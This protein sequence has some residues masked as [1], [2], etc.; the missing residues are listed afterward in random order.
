MYLIVE[1]SS[2]VQK[3]LRHTLKQQSVESAV[4]ASSM[5]EGRT[6]IE[7]QGAKIVSA[8]VDISLPDAPSGEMVEYV[9]DRN[10]PV[11]VLTGSSDGEQ[12]QALIKRGIAD[13]VVKEN[14]FSYQYAVRM[15]QRLN[16]NRAITALVVDDSAMMR[17]V[18]AGYLKLQC[19]RVIEAENGQEALEHLHSDDSI[20]LV[21]TDFN[22]PV[23]DGF[24]LVQEI[25]HR[26]DKRAISIIGLSSH[27]DADVSVQF[28][29]KGA[30]DFLQKPFKQEEFC[31][32]VT[33]NVEALEQLCALREQ[34]E[35]D[36]LTGLFNRRYFI[37]EG[38]QSISQLFSDDQ[39][40]SVALL[41]IDRFKRINDEYGHDAGDL[42][43]KQFATY[44][45]DTFGRF[46]VARYGG[47]E[48][49][50]LIPG[51]GRDKAAGLLDGFRQYISEQIFILEDDDYI[52]A[53][54]SIGL[55][56]SDIEKCS[57]LNEMLQ[58]ADLALLAAKE[59]GRNLLISHE[60]DP[61]QA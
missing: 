54:V 53:T 61:E 18:I 51:L 15:L 57:N 6:L 38:N 41:D 49:A 5:S 37:E 45:D 60:S 19:Y 29:K 31:C 27:D 16:I 33:N 52:R 20:S 44:L 55:S 43:L 42:V 39:A 8:L 47:E 9:L 48:F 24:R 30:N 56:A 14:R 7:K 28:I 59:G 58:Q 10:I 11:V 50:L 34:A 32:R 17:Q 22:M 26:Y 35:R 23:M 1:D 3:I 13:Y 46:L 21:I 2:I 4:F 12:R 40:V 36:Y 25:R